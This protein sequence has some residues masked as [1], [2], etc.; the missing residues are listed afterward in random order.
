MTET[1][2]TAGGWKFR[3]IEEG[4]RGDR[5]VLLLH[6]FPESADEWRAQLGFLARAGFRPIAPDQR[7]YSAE[8]C[9]RYVEGPYRFEVLESAGHWIPSWNRRRST[10]SCWST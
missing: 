3:V 7:G 10:E 5:P 6:G 9:A 8:G 4:S 1:T 2:V